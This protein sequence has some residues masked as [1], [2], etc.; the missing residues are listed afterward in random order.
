DP[1]LRQVH[2]VAVRADARERL[3]GEARAYSDLREA[4]RLDLPGRLIRDDVVLLDDHLVSDDVCDVVARDA[5]GD[6]LRQGDLD[7]LAAVHDAFRDAVEGAA[8]LRRDHHA[9]A[10][11]DELA[12]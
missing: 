10:D 3:A 1:P 6:A 5:T 4:E 2:P 8:V 12:G 11:V 7:L 9:L